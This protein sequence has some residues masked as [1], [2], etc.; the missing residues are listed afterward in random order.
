MKNLIYILVMG[1]ATFLVRFTPQLLIRKPIQN[2]YIKSF[3]YYVPY[4]TLAV[5][6]FPA[7]LNVTQSPLSGGCA[8]LVGLVAAYFDL[9]LFRVALCSCATVFLVE[10]FL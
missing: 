4:V 3:L 6:T 1:A 9:G 8:L 10:M 2:V 7:I 5:M